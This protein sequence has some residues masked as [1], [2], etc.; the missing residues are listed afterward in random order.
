MKPKA[1]P[2]YTRRHQRQLLDDKARLLSGFI[3]LQPPLVLL[4]QR[5]GWANFDLYWPRHF[6]D[7][8]GP[9]AASGRMSATHGRLV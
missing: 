5:L 4:S 2:R 6:S 7:A 3:D 1:D 8:S 9:K